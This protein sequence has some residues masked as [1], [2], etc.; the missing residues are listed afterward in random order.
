[1]M[2]HASVSKHFSVVLSRRFVF[3]FDGRWPETV[4]SMVMGV[5][6]TLPP[7][8]CNDDKELARPA[9]SLYLSW[10]SLARR[11]ALL[12]AVGDRLVDL[13]VH[14]TVARIRWCVRRLDGT[15]VAAPLSWRY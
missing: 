1:M 13:V 14:F 3:V 11:R 7:E 6:R 12:L 4:P 8:M 2:P 15:T 9:A 5:G 10:S